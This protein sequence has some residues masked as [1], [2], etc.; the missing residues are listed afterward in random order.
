MWAGGMAKVLS[1]RG[2]GSAGL[3]DC[4][5]VNPAEGFGVLASRIY[6][7]T[8]CEICCSLNFFP[9]AKV[10]YL[11]HA[12]L[13]YHQISGTYIPMQDSSSLQMRETTYRLSKHLIDLFGLCFD[14]FIKFNSINKL[15]ENVAH[16]ILWLGNIA[17]YS[18][19]ILMIEL[20][21]Q[22]YLGEQIRRIVLLALP[23]N[24]GC[25][26][27]R[28]SALLWLGPSGGLFAHTLLDQ[29]LSRRRILCSTQKRIGCPLVGRLI[30]FAMG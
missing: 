3:G 18:D 1:L 10:D 14:V 28:R 30:G 11:H 9:K 12:G 20:V 2:M 15:H 23:Q 13:P 26:S 6:S 8:F 21:K 19:Y 27:C 22:S 16:E 25:I 29:T 7:Y 5:S 17:E 4:A 24:K